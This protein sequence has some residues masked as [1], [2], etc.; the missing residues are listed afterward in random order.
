[1]K[2]I[3]NFSI[4]LFIG[5][6]YLGVN[7]NA[8]SSDII[9][10]EIVAYESS[11]YEWIEIYNRGNSSVD[12]TDWKFVE[13][14]TDSKPDG[15]NHG[16]NIDSS[17]DAQGDFII[18]PGEYA[19]I[20][21]KADQ[22]KSAHTNFSG[23]IIDSSWSSLSED[24]EKIG[25]KNYSGNFVEQF[26]YSSCPNSSLQRINVDSN[27]WKEHSSSDTAG[28]ENTDFKSESSSQNQSTSSSSE[29]K[30]NF[31]PRDLVINEITADPADED[32]WL[33]IF[34]NTHYD[35][36]LSDWKIIDGSMNETEL[37]GTILANSFFIVENPEGNLNNLGDQIILKFESYVI[38]KVVYGLWDD[39]NLSDNAPRV[40]DPFSIARKRDGRDTDLDFNDWVITT[41]PTKNFANIITSLGNNPKSTIVINEILPNE[42][43]FI[44]LKN[45]SGS[46]IK[47][48]NWIITNQNQNYQITQLAK[49]NPG[50][51]FLLTREQTNIALDNFKGE[52]ILHDQENNI[53]DL[54]VYEKTTGNQQSFARTKNN[55]WQWTLTI[56]PDQENIITQPNQPPVININLPTTANLN[57]TIIFDG[58]DCFDPEA[59]KITF[60]WDFGDYQICNEIICDHAYPEAGIYSI[61][62]TITD[63]QNAQSKFKHSINVGSVKEP[64]SKKPE[65]P[66]QPSELNKLIVIN[67]FLPNPNGN[68][69]QEW[70]E[71][72]NLSDQD[73]NLENFFLDDQN[74]GSK[75]YQFPK[76]T[77]I[78]AQSFLIF[79]REQT[80]IALNNSN[81]SVRLLDSNKNI[82]QEINYKKTKK[83]HSFARNKNNEF[84][85][86]AIPTPNTKNI[87][88]QG[89]TTQSFTTSSNKTNS[90]NHGLISLSEVHELSIGDQV[91]IRGTVAVEPGLLGKTTIYIAGSHGI[92]IYFYKQNWPE[93]KLG[94]VVEISGT[95]S[96]NQ[97]EKRLKIS[98]QNNIKI[99]S[100]TDPP[101]AKIITADQ[102][103]DD[104]EGS[105][106]S[107]SGEIISSRGSTF[108]LDDGNDI[109]KIYVKN[110]TEIDKKQ[111]RKFTNYKITGIVSETNSGYRIL[112]RYGS[113]IQ[114]ILKTPTTA[115]TTTIKKNILQKEFSLKNFIF[116]LIAGIIAL[117]LISL[118]SIW[119]KQKIN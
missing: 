107:I 70:I 95:L 19:I 53:T 12:L 27:T 57:E 35:I 24:G 112:P 32:E 20:A 96:L 77:I 65:A 16:L 115:E 59:E 81:D 43:E 1:M 14:Y 109:A 67:E 69:S 30:T 28:K 50:E 47:L 90:K 86:T 49:I 55:L 79:P 31:F 51:L 33:E 87:F 100:H 63:S 60:N 108:Y 15:V 13:G 84:Y 111:I 94:D 80:K 89:A 6:F 85:L 42:N 97:G 26:T 91:S 118:G 117:T 37:S 110:S 103:N 75:P 48:Q 22:F 88:V 58:S 17:K 74:Q 11:D 2:K 41:T 101:T 29:T 72:K 54:V 40:N 38:D 66:E 83:N 56:T 3:V 7:C 99:L 98:S 61:T 8:T 116:Y 10:N 44:E 36:D 119:G 78:S 5:I 93:L 82:I 106:I 45:I 52:I 39:G 68:D 104:L 25:L 21:N 105:L 18:E 4:L 9:I 71:L 102:I 76:N 113:D 23:T 92:Q 73:I 114:S 62:L 34:N 64:N 46:T